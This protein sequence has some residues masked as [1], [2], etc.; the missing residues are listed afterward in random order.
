MHEWGACREDLEASHC[1]SALRPAE[2]LPQ[3]S[4]RK[5]AHTL[6]GTSFLPRVLESPLLIAHTPLGKSRPHQELQLTSQYLITSNAPL[7]PR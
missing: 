7:M 4:S 6:Q 5:L 1:L 3:V 2:T